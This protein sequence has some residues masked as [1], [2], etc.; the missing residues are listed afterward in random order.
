VATTCSSGGDDELCKLLEGVP[1][2]LGEHVDVGAGVPVGDRGHVELT[3]IGKHTDV[4]DLVA[5]KVE[6]RPDG[7]NPATPSAMA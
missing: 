2:A 5:G 3:R 6:Q 4:E 1:N 7:R